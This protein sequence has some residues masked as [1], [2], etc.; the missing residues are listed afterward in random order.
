M[1]QSMQKESDQ[2]MT[3]YWMSQRAHPGRQHKDAAHQRRSDDDNGY[4]DMT[5]Q[6]RTHERDVLVDRQDA[7]QNAQE[8]GE[9]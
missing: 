9:D 5:R 6:T 7:E 2:H 8:D 1:I 3:L 4:A